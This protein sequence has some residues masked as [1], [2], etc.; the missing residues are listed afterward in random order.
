[1][2]FVMILHLGFIGGMGGF[3]KVKINEKRLNY[4]LNNYCI[5]VLL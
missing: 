2:G 5:V 3:C 1:M 4:L